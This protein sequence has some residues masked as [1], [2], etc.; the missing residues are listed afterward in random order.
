MSTSK[1]YCPGE[2]L[3]LDSDN[4]LHV[5]S[6]WKSTCLSELNYHRKV[7]SNSVWSCC[8]LPD[9]ACARALLLTLAA[10]HSSGCIV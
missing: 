10:W 7:A 5:S 9:I 2:Q 1:I 8:Y 4:A 6:E 3:D